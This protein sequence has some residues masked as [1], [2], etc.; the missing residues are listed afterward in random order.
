[1]SIFPTKILMASDGSREAELAART[2]ADLANSTNSELH[3]ITVAL[4]NPDPAYY[5]HEVVLRLNA[6]RRLTEPLE[7]PFDLDLALALNPM[8]PW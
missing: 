4:G 3:L 6:G 2:A 8:S 7:G 1:M 5:T